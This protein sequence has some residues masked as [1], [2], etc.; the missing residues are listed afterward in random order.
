MSYQSALEKL[1]DLGMHGMAAARDGRTIAK[2]VVTPYRLDRPHALFS[3]TKSFTSLAIG[4]CVQEGLLSPD[5]KAVSFFTNR[6]PCRLSKKMEIITVRHL[7]MM[8]TG[9]TKEPYYWPDER[10]PLDNFLRSDPEAEPGGVFLYNTAGSHVLG[11]IVE[12]V[13]GSS[14]EDYLRPRLLEPLGLDGWRWDRHPD[15]ACMGGVGLHLSTQDILKFG[16]FLLFEG[17]YNGKQLIYKEWIREATSKKITQ[18]GDPGTEWTSGYGYQFW[19]NRREDSYRADGAFGQF[20][21]VIPR[22]GLVIAMNS[23]TQDMGGMLDVIFDELVPALGPANNG[24][25][26]LF[27]PSQ[28]NEKQRRLR[29]WLVGGTPWTYTEIMT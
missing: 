3:L 5:D 19:I 10:E 2:A 26:E 22:R 6:L 8:A 9:H 25:T 24:L 1:R 12:T 15:G 29:Q 14:L 17:S 4:F 16:N 18:P 27:V 11:Y 23:G 21:V 20:C 7:L 28:E 13:S